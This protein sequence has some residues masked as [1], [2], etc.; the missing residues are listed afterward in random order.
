MVICVD[1]RPTNPRTYFRNPEEALAYAQEL[2]EYRQNQIEEPLPFS[3]RLRVIAAEGEKALRDKGGSVK[4]AIAHYLKHL[5]E[6]EKNGPG[7][8]MGEAFSRYMAA[9]LKEYKDGQIGKVTYEG[10]LHRLK[11]DQEYFNKTLVKEISPAKVLTYIERGKTNPTTRRN[12]KTRLSQPRG[13]R[14]ESRIAFED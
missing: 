12:I 3:S 4:D 7:M 5:E 6:L 11:R 13:P 10:V 1:G 14:P 8:T 9:R 2:A